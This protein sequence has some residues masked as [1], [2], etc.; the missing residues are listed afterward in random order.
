MRLRP[1]AA[2]A[3][4]DLWGQIRRSDFVEHFYA[5]RLGITLLLP[6]WERPVRELDF[7][8]AYY[9]QGPLTGYSFGVSLDF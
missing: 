4:H 5:A 6:P 7:S 3:R 2:I 9:F 1:Y 8:A